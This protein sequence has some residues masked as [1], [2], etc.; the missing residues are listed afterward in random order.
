MTKRTTLDRV[1]DLADTVDG[2]IQ[3]GATGT[4]ALRGVAGAWSKIEKV[5]SGRD[6]LTML[7][8]VVQYVLARELRDSPPDKG[9]RVKMLL[10]SWK[11][12]LAAVRRVEGVE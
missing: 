11:A 7:D 9:I 8:A 5:A 6:S 10:E 2:I 4:R 12:N 1:L 3:V